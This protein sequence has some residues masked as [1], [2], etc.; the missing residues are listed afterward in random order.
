MQCCSPLEKAVK[1][2]N[3]EKSLRRKS[4]KKELITDL[5][6]I[7]YELGFEKKLKWDKF[8][9]DGSYGRATQAA[10][11]SFAK[12]NKIKTNGRSVSNK[13]AETILQR[14]KFLPSMYILWEIGQSDLRTKKYIS[15]GTRISI[16]AI[17]LLLN[18]LGYGKQLKFAKYGADGLYG[19]ATRKAMIA[20]TRDNGCECDGDLLTR[21][22][23]DLLLEKIDAFYGPSWTKLAQYQLNEKTPLV[24]F[25]GSRF[26]GMPC[27]ADWK[28]VGLLERI[29]AYAE[30]ADVDVYVT[31][32]FRTTTIVAGAIV[33]PATYSNH[34]VGHGIDMNLIYGKRK[35]A[36]ST[37]LAKY[38]R[39]DRPVAKFLKAIIKDKDLRWGGTFRNKDA[40]HIDDGYNQNMKKW[41]K[42]YKVMQE[43]AQLGTTGK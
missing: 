9:A 28:F 13:L 4:K 15:K 25:K 8:Q 27:R 43:A 35:W 11:K 39:V 19:K 12:K 31:S 2:A 41:R 6:R 23:V 18:E 29:N 14:Y 10:V 37:E 36:N 24:F 33:R 20:F 3:L 16:V 21:P 34:L 17:Q 26:I 32:S 7:L 5:Q 30:A 40:V 1:K 22:V 38:P 42:R